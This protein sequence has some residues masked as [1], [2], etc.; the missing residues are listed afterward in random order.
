M[1]TYPY[2]KAR[3]VVLFT[4]PQSAVKILISS[5]NGTTPGHFTWIASDGVGNI[6]ADAFEIAGLTSATLGKTRELKY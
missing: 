2:D 4:H 6:G 1:M 5:T 3:A